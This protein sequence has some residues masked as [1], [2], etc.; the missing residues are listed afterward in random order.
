MR[1]I[2][3]YTA[4][5]HEICTCSCGWIDSYVNPTATSDP[6]Y[7]VSPIHLGTNHVL[8]EHPGETWRFNERPFPDPDARWTH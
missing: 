4:T 3:I 8:D 6:G 5:E 2:T 7:P 1:T